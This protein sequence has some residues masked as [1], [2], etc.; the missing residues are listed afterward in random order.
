ML[1]KGRTTMESRGGP[2]FSGADV[3][4]GLRVG[5]SPTSE[6]IDPDR[7]GDVLELRRAEIGDIESEPPLDLPIGVLGKT[8]RAGLGDALEP[9]GD[10]DAVAHE[11]AVAL[12][13]YVAE[14]NADAEFDAPLRR[15]AAVALGHAVLHFDRAA[16]R[17][18]YAAELDDEPVAGAF[19]YASVVDFDRRIDEIAAQRPK[20]RERALFV[21][22]GEAAVADDVG[23]EDRC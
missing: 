9:G 5:R 8:D 21:G 17:V 16:H 23:G 12:L 18:D 19:E 2:A 1:A 3:G 4:D 6:R 20:P 15:Q 22:A 7:I 10:I 11:V 13:D 14:M